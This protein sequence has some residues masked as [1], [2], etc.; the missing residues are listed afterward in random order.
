MRIFKLYVERKSFGSRLKKAKP[1]KK[2]ALI[3]ARSIAL[4]S[5]KR[6]IKDED[7]GFSDPF[8]EKNKMRN[9]KQPRKLP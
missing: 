4:S 5:K 3:L 7:V 9:Y 1:Q 2:S 6:I 8:R